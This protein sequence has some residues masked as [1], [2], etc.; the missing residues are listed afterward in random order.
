MLA[1]LQ[2][3]E[4]QYA[5]SLATLDRFLAETKSTEAGAPGGQGQRPVPPGALPGGRRRAEA[6]H[7]RQPRAQAGMAAAADGDL[8]RI[9]ARRGEAAK[10]AEAV[11]AKNP[12]DKRAQL[13]LAAVYQQ[14]DM[15]DKAAAVLEKLRATR[16]ADRGQGIPP[17]LRHLPEHGRQGE[18]G[19]RGDQRRPA[20]GRPQARLPD[21]PG[22]GPGVL[23]LRSGGP[24]D[25]RL[26]EG[27]AAGHRTARPTSTSPACCGRKT[28]FPRPR[29][30][31]SR[32]SPR[33]S[34]SP[35]TPRRSSRCRA[36]NRRNANCATDLRGTT[37]RIGIC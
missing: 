3:Q 28:A 14:N 18:G 1:Q 15:F 31:P 26:Q 4:D 30:P 36:S 2:L 17:A 24:G 34:R 19:H 9:A 23:F 25:R 35:T 32:R 13:N 7:R 8:R 33:A 21:L 5:E 11:A 29:K 16:P 10:M 20:E 22:A 37:A 6:G 27:R 12:N